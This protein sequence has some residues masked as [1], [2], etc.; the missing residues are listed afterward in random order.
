MEQ[1]V[2]AQVDRLRTAG[3]P[4]DS[5]RLACERNRREI[6]KAGSVA[7]GEENEVGSVP[8]KIAVIPYLHGVS[9]RLKKVASKYGVRVV[10]SAQNK[11]AKICPAVQRLADKKE[12]RTDG[13]GIRHG[14]KF[15][16]CG[17][18]VVY[19]IPF[20]CGK[21]YIGQTG[22]CLN[23]RLREHNSSLKGAPYSHLAMHCKKCTGRPEL[24]LTL[25]DGN[26]NHEECACHPELPHTTVLDKHRKRATR[27]IMEAFYIKKEEKTCVSQPSVLLSDAEFAFLD[28][29]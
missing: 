27:E 21:K 15:V 10:F 22:R 19:S 24:P 11:V 26:Q 4:D 13:C 18:D 2:A 17:K 12:K 9:H 5:V 29:G 25:T 28:K 23:V 20:K 8:D 14:I 6:K 3:H 16:E 1:S 7:R